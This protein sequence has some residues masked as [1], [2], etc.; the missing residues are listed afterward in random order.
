[1]EKSSL[2]W[3]GRHLESMKTGKFYVHGKLNY[4]IFKDG[5][6]EGNWTHAICLDLENNKFYDN[7]SSSLRRGRSIKKWFIQH[8]KDNQYMSEIHRIYKLAVSRE[9]V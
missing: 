3:H 2:Q 8:D 5:T 4:K 6:S 7:T 9:H 1:M